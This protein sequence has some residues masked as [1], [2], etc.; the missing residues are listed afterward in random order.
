MQFLKEE[1]RKEADLHGTIDLGVE[2][3]REMTE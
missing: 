3:G 1:G 2:D